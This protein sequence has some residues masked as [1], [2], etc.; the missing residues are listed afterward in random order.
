MVK[1]VYGTMTANDRYSRE[2]LGQDLTGHNVHEESISAVDFAFL[3]A[4]TFGDIELE[5]D[6]LELFVAQARKILQRLPDLPP[7][8][9]ADAAHLLKGSARGIGAAAAAAAAESYEAAASETRTLAFPALASAFAAAE[10]AIAERL[11]T[12]RR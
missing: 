9:Q 10:H 5:R 12:L 1:E 2:S 6:V 4:Q 11:A 7:A 3:A 8:E